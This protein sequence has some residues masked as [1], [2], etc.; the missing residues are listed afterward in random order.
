MIKNETPYVGKIKLKFE[1]EPHYTGSNSGMLNKIHLNLGFTKLV[2]RVLPFR[3]AKGYVVDKDKIDLIEHYT[4]GFIRDYHVDNREPKD[5]F[6]LY[7]SFLTSDGEYIGD[8]KTAWWYYENRMEVCDDYPHGVAVAI[9]DDSYPNSLLSEIKGYY[10]YTHRGG[11]LFK[12]GDRLF[13]AE[14]E[15]SQKD[16]TYEQWNVWFKKFEDKL[17]NADGYDKEYLLED[18]IKSIIPFKLRGYKVIENWKEAKQ[19]AINFSKYLN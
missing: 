17:F 7:N 18:G 13:D 1:K 16:Y 10:G 19:A 4:G 5:E 9:K 2:S 6:T 12:I 8:I 14:Y 15:P 11:Q 3:D